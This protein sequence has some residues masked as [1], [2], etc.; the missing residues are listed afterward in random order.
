MVGELVTRTS[1]GLSDCQRRIRHFSP[2]AQRGGE[3]KRDP[4]A[5]NGSAEAGYVE[6]FPPTSGRV[7]GVIAVGI[8]LATALYALLDGNGGVGAPV[9]WG[10]SFLGILSYA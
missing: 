3:M 1:I 4:E 2:T 5:T 10:A 6:K 8:C 7:M 9:A